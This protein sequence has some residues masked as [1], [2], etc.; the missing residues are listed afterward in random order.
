MKIFIIF[1]IVFQIAVLQLN[2]DEA[3]KS[4]IENNA[5]LNLHYEKLT[6]SKEI[7]KMLI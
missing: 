5:K 1:F 2:I 7:S 4:T 3:I 6:E